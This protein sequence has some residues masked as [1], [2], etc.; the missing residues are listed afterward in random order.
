MSRPAAAPPV[1]G[2]RDP[3]A[4]DLVQTLL[5]QGLTV[6]IRVSGGSMRPLLQGGELVEVAPLCHAIPRLGDILFILSRQSTPIIH[7]L[8]WRRSRNGV[9]QFLTKGDACSGF[10][11]FIPASQVLGR[12]ERIFFSEQKTVSLQSPML[13]LRANFI[14]SRVVLAHAVRKLRMWHCQKKCRL[15]PSV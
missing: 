4:L 2:I 15:P 12:V 1:I 5:R 8:I 3:G 13:R 11:G 14:V 6:R 9:P 10:D 7:R